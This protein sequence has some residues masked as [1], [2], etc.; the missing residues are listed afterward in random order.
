MCVITPAKA[1]TVVKI[2]PPGV[3]GCR[4]GPLPLA[5]MES[6]ARTRRRALAESEEPETMKEDRPLAVAAQGAVA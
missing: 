4:T 6:L 2:F 1:K 3:A 5:I